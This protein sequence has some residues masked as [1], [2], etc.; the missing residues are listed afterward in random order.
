MIKKTQ[1]GQKS[2]ALRSSGE[3]LRRLRYSGAG[4]GSFFQE[5]KHDE[6]DHA[7]TEGTALNCKITL[8]QFVDI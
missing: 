4:S 2:F 8:L 3:G 5:L 7:V 6:S 1:Q